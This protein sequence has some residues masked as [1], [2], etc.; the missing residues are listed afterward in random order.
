MARAMITRYGMSDKYGMMQLEDVQHQYLGGNSTM[1]CSAQ[2]A[3]EVDEEV[4]Q[5][6]ARAHQ[7]AVELISQHKEEMQ[8]AAAVLLSKET[9]TGK[10]FMDILRKHGDVD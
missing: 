3:A 4:R 8:E 10:E 9:I 2:T 7:K 1:I 5:V 6:I